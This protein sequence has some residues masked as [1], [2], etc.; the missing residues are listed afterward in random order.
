MVVPNGAVDELPVEDR[1][2]AIAE[3]M[4]TRMSE[5]AEQAGLDLAGV[6]EQ[7]ADLRVQV[8][9]RAAVAK[10]RLVTEMVNAASR[11]RQ[12]ADKAEDQ[13]DQKRALDL[14]YELERSAAYL[15]AHTFEEIGDDVTE[16]AQEHVW[17][18]LG[19]AFIIG[20][21]LGLIIGSSR[22]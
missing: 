14:A 21:V 15:E 22:R 1:V 9:E 13:D 3:D 6:Q 7:M 16:T 12:E 18:A 11:I 19:I 20:L 5:V 4:R 8:A 2:E 10:D 17:K